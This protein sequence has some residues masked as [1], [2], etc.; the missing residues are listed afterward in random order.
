MLQSCPFC[1]KQDIGLEQHLL[2]CTALRDRLREQDEKR[3]WA[4]LS[5]QY[6]ETNSP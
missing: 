4:K 6:T 5:W 2:N 3:A 1:H